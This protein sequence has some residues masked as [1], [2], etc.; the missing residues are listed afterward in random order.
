MFFSKG[1]SDITSCLVLTKLR[2]HFIVRARASLRKNEQS[3]FSYCVVRRSEDLF[4]L[5]SKPEDLH[6]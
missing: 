5:L 6:E 1:L 4:H 3:P 2:A